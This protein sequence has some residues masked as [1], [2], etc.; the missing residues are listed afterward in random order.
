MPLNPSLSARPQLQCR[1]AFALPTH[2]HAS[3]S[4][5]AG[6]ERSVEG[7]NVPKSKELGIRVTL[8]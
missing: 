4:T 6:W 5:C 3:V 7:L 1:Q 8:E 2:H